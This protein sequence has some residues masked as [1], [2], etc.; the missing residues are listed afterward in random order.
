V[1]LHFSLLLITSGRFPRGIV[2]NGYYALSADVVGLFVGVLC[3]TQTKIWRKGEN[4]R[5]KY[6]EC[7]PDIT[8]GHSLIFSLL[9]EVV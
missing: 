3:E 6:S 5:F 4:D 1:T 7:V 2:V 9:Y 8:A